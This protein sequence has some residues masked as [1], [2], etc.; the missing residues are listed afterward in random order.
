MNYYCWASSLDKST[1]E[2]QLSLMFLQHIYQYAKKEIFCFS[3]F[4]TGTFSKKNLIMHKIY[5]KKNNFYNNYIK[6]FYGIYLMWIY[7]FKKK[8]IIYIGYLPIWNFLI[9]ILLPPKVIL[10]PITGNIINPKKVIRL[11]NLKI[12]IILSSIISLI[13]LR[14]RYKNFIFAHEELY[15][16]F[17]KYLP[18]NILYNYQLLYFK[19]SKKNL[20]NKNNLLIYNAGHS[21]KNVKSML[22]K[23]I[24][25]KKFKPISIVGKN[26]K[27][28]YV[29]NLGFLKH[30]ELLKI[31]RKY[32]YSIISE[33]NF[34]SFFVLDAISCNTKLIFNPER[35]KKD[36]H[37]YFIGAE[38]INLEK[39]LEKKFQYNSV[40]AKL[41]L[42]IK[43]K[44]SLNLDKYL[45][46][47]L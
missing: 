21:A 43:K 37:K 7:Y 4:G 41:N 15:I 19:I 10:G 33:E 35:Y 1:G 26:I 20:S 40:K 42:N 22:D 12:I 34:F 18:Q 27:N 14:L 47:V 45:K 9:F 39:I 17:K 5:K 2:G 32:R 13:I 31:L 24:K 23:L 28:K 29:E 46:N 6:I 38:F 16:F 36:M 11:F 44:I 25:L 8:K 30:Y 3:N